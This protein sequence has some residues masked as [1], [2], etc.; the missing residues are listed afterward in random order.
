MTNPIKA[1]RRKPLPTYTIL[2]PTLTMDGV[3]LE[4]QG[5]RPNISASSIMDHVAD[6]FEVSRKDLR[7]DRRTPA[8]SRARFAAMYAMRHMTNM[9]LP[10]IGKTLGKRDHT[11][12]MYGLHRAEDYFRDDEDFRSRLALVMNHG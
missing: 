8:I 11:T 2:G 10:L 6:A 9:S 5:W 3:V 4:G 1:V 12:I 7:G